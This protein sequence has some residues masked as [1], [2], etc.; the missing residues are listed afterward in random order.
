MRWKRPLIGKPQCLIC[1]REITQR[2][3]S[4]V[5][6]QPDTFKSPLGQNLESWLPTGGG[7]K[8]ESGHRYL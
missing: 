4:G 2:R 8:E 7:K 3:Q 6:A 1:E 5:V